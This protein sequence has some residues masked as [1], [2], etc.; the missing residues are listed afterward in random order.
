MELSQ[1]KIFFFFSLQL[2]LKLFR[3]QLMVKIR[4]ISGSQANSGNTILNLRYR[5]SLKEIIVVY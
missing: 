1:N 4:L 5:V 3:M 2:H